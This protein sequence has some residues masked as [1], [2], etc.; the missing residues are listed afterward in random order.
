MLFFYLSFLLLAAAFAWPLARLSDLP[1]VA[2]ALALLAFT[3]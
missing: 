3:A 2:L 1:L